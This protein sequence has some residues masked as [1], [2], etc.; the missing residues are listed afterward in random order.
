MPLQ[1]PICVSNIKRVEEQLKDWQ[2]VGT[3]AA[4]HGG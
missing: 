4:R 2:E 3:G 1:H